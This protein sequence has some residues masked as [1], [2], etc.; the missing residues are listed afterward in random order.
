MFLP[1][2]HPPRARKRAELIAAYLLI[3]PFFFRWS[4]D[5]PS[6]DL[7]PFDIPLGDIPV[8]SGVLPLVSD[9]PAGA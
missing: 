9:A 6:F 3:L 1:K 4:F 7:V 2:E 5:M 8:V